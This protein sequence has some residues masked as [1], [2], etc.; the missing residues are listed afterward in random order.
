MVEKELIQVLHIQFQQSSGTSDYYNIYYQ[1]Q[2]SKLGFNRLFLVIQKT[3][4]WDVQI[5]TVNGLVKVT[6]AQD[7]SISDVSD[8]FS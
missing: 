2:W 8:M 3:F 6:D 1:G 5:Y 7:E 4:S